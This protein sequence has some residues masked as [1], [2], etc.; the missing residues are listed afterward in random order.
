MTLVLTVYRGLSCSL[1]PFVPMLYRRRLAKGKELPGRLNERQ[2]RNLAAR[3]QGQLIWMHGASIGESK[4]LLE[5]AQALSERRAGLSFLFTSH[6]ASSAGIVSKGMPP[7]AMQ[8]MAPFDTPAT[9]K[10]FARHWSPDLCVFAEGDI[11]PNL[12]QACRAQGAKMALVN[13][14]MTEKSLKGWQRARKSAR[15]VFNHFDQILAADTLTADGL[16]PWF[17]HEVRHTGNVK[18]AL[19]ARAAKASSN[20]AGTG[21]RIFQG[22]DIVILGASTHAGEEALLLDALPALPGTPRLIL[23]PRHI[24]RADEIEA[25]IAS[26]GR[27]YARRSQGHAVT[28]ETQ[29]LLADTFGEMNAWYKTADRV[30][31]GGGH[32]IG[33]GGHSPLEPLSFGLPIVTGPHTDNFSDTYKDLYRNNWAYT[34]RTSEEVAKLL[35]ESAPPGAEEL[36]AYFHSCE[37]AL[38]Q[39]LDTLSTLLPAKEA[40]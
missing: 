39:T 31:L 24:E 7:R 19:A 18:V 40:S 37:A 11:W 10:R 21:P 17:D 20:V 27:P 15:H 6:T 29:I 12:L 13:A 9:A 5:L 8:Q 35:Q 28:P 4:L 30:Y 34:A 2:A 1:A 25:L 33:I 22:D 16:A 3:P 14:R 26:S 23:A 36:S 32:Q 38:E